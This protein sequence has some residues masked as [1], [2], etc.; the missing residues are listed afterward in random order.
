MNEIPVIEKPTP[1]KSGVIN[2][3]SSLLS[4][5]IELRKQLIPPKR[6]H[7]PDRTEIWYRGV[8]SSKYELLPGIYRDTVTEWAE[9]TTAEAWLDDLPSTL[10]GD[11]AAKREHRRLVYERE[12]MAAFERDCGPLMPHETEQELYFGARHYLIP[13]RLLDWSL[14][15]LVALFMA[16][17]KDGSQPERRTGTPVIYAMEPAKH[18]NSEIKNQFADDVEEAIDVVT[19]YRSPPHYPKKGQKKRGSVKLPTPMIMPIRPHTKVGRIER[20][21]SRFTLHCH[22]APPIALANRSTLQCRA[23]S[24][25]GAH[26]EEMI[27]QLSRLNINQFTV[28]GTLDRLVQEIKLKF[29][30]GQK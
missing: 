8:S 5:E 28:Y 19:T 3:V 7:E 10:A 23:V 14:N 30:Y 15:P 1:P 18:L 4:W 25:T 26:N 21:S 17:F 2:S 20:Q 24:D 11:S 16:I 9:K 6:V 27:E 13:N 22:G 12:M 29:R